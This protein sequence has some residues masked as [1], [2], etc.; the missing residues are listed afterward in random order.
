MEYL[1]RNAVV[2]E[3]TTHVVGIGS[4][5]HIKDEHGKPRTYQVVSKHSARPSE[6]LISHESPIG[7]ALMGQA[8]GATVEYPTPAGQTKSVSIVGIE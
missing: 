7:K 6:G 4:T 5:V 2:V 8:A 1:L 3:P